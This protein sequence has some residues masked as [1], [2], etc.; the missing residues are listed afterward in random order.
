M[1]VDAAVCETGVELSMGAEPQVMDSSTP[2]EVT[3]N[4]PSGARPEASEDVLWENESWCVLFIVGSYQET[5]ENVRATKK[6]EKRKMKEQVVRKA[7]RARL[8]HVARVLYIAV[9]LAYLLLATGRVGAIG[10][11]AEGFFR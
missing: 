1:N 5:P 9:L 6:I 11:V 10:I 2:A 4:V 3:P 8:D 7:L